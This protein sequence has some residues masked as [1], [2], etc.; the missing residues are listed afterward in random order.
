MYLAQALRGQGRGAEAEAAQ[1]AA[2][3][4]YGRLIAAR[5]QDYRTNFATLIVPPDVARAALEGVPLPAEP[6]APA[7]EP[8]V[9]RSPVAA[10]STFDRDAELPAGEAAV[11]HAPSGSSFSDFR[12]LARTGASVLFLARDELLGRDVVIKQLTPHLGGTQSAARLLREAHIS[13]ALRHPHVVTVY[14]VGTTGTHGLPFLVLEYYPGGT[15]QDAIRALN[16]GP[17]RPAFTGADFRRCLSALISV[18]DALDFAHRRGIVHRDPKPSNVFHGAEGEVVL[19]DWGLATWWN[20][21]GRAANETRPDAAP[22]PGDAPWDAQLTVTGT[23]MGTAAYMAPETTTGGRHTPQ[24]DIYSVGVC[25]FELLTGRRYRLFTDFATTMRMA[26]EHRERPRSIRPDVP[27]ELD[28]IC[29]RATAIAP[30]DRYAIAAD[31]AAE[32]RAWLDGT[33]R[34]IWGRLYRA[35][36]GR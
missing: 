30:A 16:D 13:A 19:G 10:D 8:S 33:P 4:D 24:S 32:L 35:I 27:R 9:I 12:L 28:A 6:G 18:C 3:A 34:T 26:P 5:P 20:R 7:D 17:G 15:L 14:S 29:A 23:V 11:L 31:L 2:V 21:D 25:L 36:S 1:K 22:T